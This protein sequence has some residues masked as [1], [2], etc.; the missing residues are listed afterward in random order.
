M[1]KL[2]PRQHGSHFFVDNSFKCIFFNENIVI[3][4][5]ISLTYGPEGPVDKKVN[6][7]SGNGLAPNKRKAIT[8][9]PIQW[10]IYASPSLNEL[11]GLLGKTFTE[12]LILK[13]DMMQR[14]LLQAF[15]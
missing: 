2:R 5:K 10:H 1:N 4:I 8:R 7:G 13:I 12:I 9:T 11:I 3:L 15:S 14:K 6:I